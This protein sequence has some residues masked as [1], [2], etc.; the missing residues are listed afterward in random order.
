MGGDERTRFPAG[1]EPIVQRRPGD[2][3]H[4]VPLAPAGTPPQRPRQLREDDSTEPPPLPPGGG[5]R[6]ADGYSGGAPRDRLVEDG[7]FGEL[8]V[9]F[10]I[11]ILLGIVT[12][13][14]YRFW[15]KTRI[16]KYIWSRSSFRGERFEY[17]GTG[18]ELFLGFLFAFVIFGPPFIGFYAWLYF[19]PPPQDPNDPQFLARLG[20]LYL[21]AFGLIILAFFFLHVATFAAYRYRL[22]RTLW[23]GIR[24]SVSGSAWTYGCL[25]F[26]LSLLNGISLGWTKPW[27]DTVLIKYRLDRTSIG[28]EPLT[29]NIQAGPLYGTFAAAWVITLVTTIVAIA[30]I[31]GV[32]FSFRDLMQRPGQQPPMSFLVLIVLLYLLI[33]VVWLATINFYRAA[34]LRQTAATS[35]VSGLT[36]NF[37]VGGWRLLW[38]NFSNFLLVL[39]SLGLLLP[40]VIL[41]YARFVAEYLRIEGELDYAKVRQSQDRGPRYGEG[42]A[43]FFGLGVI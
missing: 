40:L 28:S 32:V 35:R 19:D 20:L 41:R 31:V 18:L 21:V 23:H 26:G 29:C 39:I 8:F 9:L 17:S 42:I 15:G 1:Q 2:P 37:G 11:N 4:Q 34:L 24:G 16:R 27:A 13:G 7:R 38:F 5:R 22:S 12:L 36:F 10:I 43:E 3:R 33:P 25:G 14:I 30:G 6:A